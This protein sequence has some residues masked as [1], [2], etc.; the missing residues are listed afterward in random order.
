MMM[1]MMMMMIRAIIILQFVEPACGEL[2]IVPLLSENHVVVCSMEW[3]AI[4]EIP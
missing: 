4:L 2:D 1:M 3:E